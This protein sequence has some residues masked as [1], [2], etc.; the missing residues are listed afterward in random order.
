MSEPVATLANYK[1]E[2]Y[3][4]FR[5]KTMPGYCCMVLDDRA[6]ARGLGKTHDLACQ[7]AEDLID[8]MKE[9][10]AGQHSQTRTN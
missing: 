6:E 3:V 1:G 9:H 4:V 5:S 8:K 2:H 7:I 10:D